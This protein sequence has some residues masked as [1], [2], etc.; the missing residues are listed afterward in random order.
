[1]MD[2]W[3]SFRSVV[4][5]PIDKSLSF[6]SCLV[7]YLDYVLRIHG[8]GLSLSILITTEIYFLHLYRRL[9][10]FFIA[11]NSEK[12]SQCA[13]MWLCSM[14]SDMLTLIS[15]CSSDFNLKESP[16]ISL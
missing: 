16:H 2:Y 1:M 14:C 6:N 11:Q 13:G 5:V 9:Y 4:D 8:L 15:A 7:A 12:K 10:H 3:P